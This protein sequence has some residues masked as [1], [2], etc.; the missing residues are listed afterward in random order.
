MI[1]QLNKVSKSFGTDEILNDITFSV[2]ENDRIGIIGRNGCGK[3]TLLNIISGSMPYSGG[4]CTA[5]KD[6]RIGFLR[7]T[8]CETMNTTI[9]EEMTSVFKSVFETE[10]DMR[11]LEK[12]ISKE[13]DDKKRSALLN[14]YAKKSEMFEKADGFLIKTKINTILT[15]MGFDKFDL[16]MKADKLSGGEKTKLSFAKLLL[17]EREILLLDEPTNH[18]DFKTVLWLEEYLKDYKGALLIVSHDRY[19]LD[20][21]VTSVCEIE[22]GVLTR[23]KGNYTAYTLLKSD[24]VKRQ[25]KEYEAQQK[26]IAKL[27]EYIAK[28]KVRASTAA[29]AKSRE[30]ALERMELIEKPSIASNSANIKFEY[31]IQ[32]PFDILDVKDVDI[33]VGSGTSEK[34]LAEHISFEIKRGEKL[35]IIGDNGIGKSSFLKVLQGILPH[36]GGG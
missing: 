22:Y 33:R 7:Q 36:S 32:P 34:I 24:S 9:M 4:T 14:Q 6:V 19:F 12:E 31:K 30:K 13:S 16:N 17:E 3:T 26:E 21:V 23:Y 11:R 15:G 1:L 10:E 5:P 29:S 8:G 25:Q 28:N 35:G 2:N 18:L 27:E 20:K